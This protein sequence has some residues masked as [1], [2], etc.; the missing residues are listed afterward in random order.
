MIEKIVLDYLNKSLPDG[1]KAYIERPEGEDP[2]R[3]VLVQKTSSTEVNLVESAMIAIQSYAESLYEA[4]SL[5]ETVKAIMR[6]A[7]GEKDISAA[8]LNSDY[9][10]NDKARKKYRY[11][12]VYDVYSHL[13]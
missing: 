2:Q 3:Y 9:E 11:Q 8:R 5:N 1:I 4:A 13:K 6:L 12:A 7:P 10:Y